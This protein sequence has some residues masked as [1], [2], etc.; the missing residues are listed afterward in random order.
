[1]KND[2]KRDEKLNDLYVFGL[3]YVAF[4]SSAWE[5]QYIFIRYIITLA[6]TVI[7]SGSVLAV[8]GGRKTDSL[9]SPV[10]LWT[11]CL[12]AALRKSAVTVLPVRVWSSWTRRL[13]T[14]LSCSFADCLWQ[15]NIDTHRHADTHTLTH[16]HTHAHT[17]ARTHAR[18][19][20]LTHT[21]TRTHARTSTHGLRTH[22]RMY[23]AFRVCVFKGHLQMAPWWGPVGFT[24]Y[25]SYLPV[26]S[27]A[28]QLV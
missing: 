4:L 9:T 16:T 7:I 20:T 1:M 3:S 27:K 21:H 15:I 10:R 28:L 23:P 5:N 6:V 12:E 17:H 14:R 11:Q 26:I 22:T 19:H 25:R 2:G 18:T 13:V 8:P 24:L